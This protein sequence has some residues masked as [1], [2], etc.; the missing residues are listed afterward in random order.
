MNVQNYTG[1]NRLETWLIGQRTDNSASR[2]YARMHNPEHITVNDRSTLRA[3]K[4]ISKIRNVRSNAGTWERRGHYI[5][6]AV[7][8]GIY[9]TTYPVTFID[10]PL[11]F[12]DIAWAYGLVRMTRTG[13]NIGSEVGSWFD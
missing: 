6:G 1:K 9:A 8:A 4:D 3:V 10:G 12:V 11:P 5:G 13:A 7:A 2:N